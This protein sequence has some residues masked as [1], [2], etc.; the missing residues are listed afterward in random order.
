MTILR[1]PFEEEITTCYGRCGCDVFD[2][3]RG[4]KFIDNSCHCDN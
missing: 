3:S 4:C 2:N 1:K